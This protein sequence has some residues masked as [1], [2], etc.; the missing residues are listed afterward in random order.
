ML[1]NRSVLKCAIAGFGLAGFGVLSLAPVTAQVALPGVVETAPL[2]TDA[3]STGTLDRASGALAPT[4]WRES[5]AQ[6][7]EFLLLYAPARPSA[8]SIGDAMRRTLLSPGPGPQGAAP[9]LGGKKLLALSRAGFLDEAATVASISNAQRGDPWTGQAHAISDLL[10]GKID[11]AC[12]RNAA[13]TSGREELFWVKLR[14]LCYAA[15]GETDAA[16]LTLNIL[17]DHGAFTGA[18][19]IFLSAV[20][21]G[22]A[23][24]SPPLARSALQYA[25]AKRLEMPLAPGLLKQADGGVLV[26][27]S[28]DSQAQ[29]STRIAAAER[30]VAM[31]VMDIEVLSALLAGAVFEVADISAAASAA[32]DRANDP[33][34]DAL[35]YQSIAAMS[36]PEFLRDKAQRIALALGL[37]DTFH[38]AYALSLLYANE[39]TALEGAIVTAE[40]AGR[41]ALARMAVSDSVGA[42]RWLNAV[43]GPNPSVSA[44]PEPQ[45]MAF[46]AHVNLLAVLDP[47][48]AAQVARGAGVS[49]LSGEP[50]YSDISV[51]AHTDPA[52]MAAI[53]EA[54]FDAAVDGK[55]GQ[56]GLAA[57]AASSGAGPGENRVNAVVINQSFRVAGLPELRRRHDFERAWAATFT[58]EADG[59]P[60]GQRTTA[61]AAATASNDEGGLA[62]RIKPPVKR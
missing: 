21:T 12:R 30:A 9:S 8:P 35:L 13:L 4:L 52:V 17:R 20:A 25:I 33:L 59:A 23:P 56:A 62:P 41:F 58:A 61:A 15:A 10:S 5:D 32:R 1:R 16:D 18:D 40:E 49:L 3:F 19:E 43:L 38:R 24:K 54:A 44:L 47:I 31:G 26:A 55:A 27:I 42:G 29:M 60:L 50:V 14:V 51:R 22:V 39:I 57:L 6:T 28:R 7:L 46:I 48:T 37:A 34:T 36:A 11:G 53:L 45:A 2:A